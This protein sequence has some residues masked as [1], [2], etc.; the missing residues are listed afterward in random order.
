MISKDIVLTLLSILGHRCTCIKSYDQSRLIPHRVRRE[1]LIP[2]KMAA[3]R[4]GYARKNTV[5][6]SRTSYNH[7]TTHMKYMDLLRNRA[8]IET[9]YYTVVLL[10]CVCEFGFNVAFNNFSVILRRCLVATGSS[11]LTYAHSMLP[12]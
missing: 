12:H 9:Y 10:V 8:I 5:H 7:P 11:M 2:V 3:N 6:P 4:V 1:F